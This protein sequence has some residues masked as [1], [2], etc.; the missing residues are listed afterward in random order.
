VRDNTGMGFPAIDI[1]MSHNLIY[2]GESGVWTSPNNNLNW[3]EGNIDYD[4][5]LF[6]Q[7][8]GIGF[9]SEDSPCRDAGTL[10]LPEGIFLS[11]YD[12]Y[13]YSRVYGDN[14]DIG[15]VEWT[16]GQV[17]N[18][19]NEINIEEENLLVY[20]NPAFISEMRKPGLNIVWLGR[21]RNSGSME[22]EVFNIF[23]Q[24]VYKSGIIEN[25]FTLEEPGVWD[26][27]NQEG[28]LVSSGFYIVR[29]KAGN[30][31]KVQQKLTVVK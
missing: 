27:R 10:D 31:Y 28:K 29:L 21:E 14:I 24:K 22:L 19:F 5:Q 15:A 4:P 23:G 16:P 30:E 6:E 3:L 17:A 20:P 26:F 8:I 18:N 12:V 11:E 9:L 13:G 1:N 2:G 25:G 7:E